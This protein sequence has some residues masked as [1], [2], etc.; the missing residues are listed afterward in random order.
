MTQN[1]LDA[2][3][4]GRQIKSI[5]DYVRDCEARTAKGEQLDLAGL[6]DKVMMV[7]DAIA[8]LPE[9][10]AEPLETQMKTL[11]EALER[12]GRAIEEQQA[13]LDGE[14]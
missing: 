5:L 4:T 14:E 10:E 11:I 13:A 7:C 2:A 12:L 9:D 6:D 3:E 1:T 8:E